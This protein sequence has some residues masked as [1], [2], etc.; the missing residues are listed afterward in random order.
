VQPQNL[1]WKMQQGTPNMGGVTPS[2][3]IKTGVG[4]GNYELTQFTTNP[5]PPTNQGKGMPKNTQYVMSNAFNK[6]N[7]LNH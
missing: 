7:R 2:R 6:G 4:Q 1:P 5:T 3:L